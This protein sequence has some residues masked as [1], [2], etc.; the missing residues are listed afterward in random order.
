MT[1]H[2]VTRSGVE[3]YADELGTPP[4]GEWIVHSDHPGTVSIGVVKDLRDGTFEP[5]VIPTAGHPT[6]ILAPPKGSVEEAIEAILDA[7]GIT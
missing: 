1:R 5:I 7:L 3:Y 4:R 6:G 2:S